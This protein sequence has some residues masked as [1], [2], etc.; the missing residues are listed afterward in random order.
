M[1]TSENLLE[2]SLLSTEKDYQV[3]VITVPND[4]KETV[5]LQRYFLK[6]IQSLNFKTYYTFSLP[7]KL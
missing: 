7:K 3:L 2:A 5:S 1:S 4:Y 6:Q